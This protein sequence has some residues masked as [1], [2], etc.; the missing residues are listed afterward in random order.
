MEWKIYPCRLNIGSSSE[1]AGAY[2]DRCTPDEAKHCDEDNNLNVNSVNVG[3]VYVNDW[4][5]FSEEP[6]CKFS[7]HY[8]EIFFMPCSILETAI[9]ALPYSNG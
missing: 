4:K 6:A 7:K 3:I 8:T 5:P 9:R 2:P 1:F